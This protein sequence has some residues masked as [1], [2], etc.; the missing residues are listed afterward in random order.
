MRNVDRIARDS[1][2][3]RLAE[4]EGEADEAEKEEQEIYGGL[5]AVEICTPTLLLIPWR[6]GWRLDVWT[7]SQPMFCP[8]QVLK[9]HKQRLD[10]VVIYDVRYSW[11]LDTSLSV[12]LTLASFHLSGSMKTAVRF[13]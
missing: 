9:H 11:D 8:S 6:I 7:T 3:Q 1:V 4:T 5:S 13:S 2:K 10:F 12:S